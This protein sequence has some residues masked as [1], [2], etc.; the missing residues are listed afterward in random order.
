MGF[1]EALKKRIE[2]A[3][4]RATDRRQKELEKVKAQIEAEKKEMKLAEKKKE[5]LELR[6]KRKTYEPS[7]LDRFR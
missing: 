2:T 7:I 1:I 5:L 6:E 4:E 3:D